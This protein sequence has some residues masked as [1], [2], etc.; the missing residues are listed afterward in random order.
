MQKFIAK[1]GHLIQ[2]VISGVDRLVFRGSLR[3]IQYGHGMMGYL[4][5][6][7]VLLTE[8]GKHAEQLTKQIKEASL[9]EAGRLQRRCCR[10]GLFNCRQYRIIRCASRKPI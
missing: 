6:K 3:S 4:W 8:F 9:A 1:F 7:Q 10:G 2:G 5:H